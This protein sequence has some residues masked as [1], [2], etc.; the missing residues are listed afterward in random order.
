MACRPGLRDYT[1]QRG[2]RIARLRYLR[3]ILVA[4]WILRTEQ[5]ALAAIRHG[6]RVPTLGRDHS[7]YVADLMGRYVA[8]LMGREEI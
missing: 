6:L 5:V 7:K 4:P 1:H 8:P 3:S 2:V